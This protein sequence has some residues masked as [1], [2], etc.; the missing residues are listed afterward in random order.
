MF[1]DDECR[2][3]KIAMQRASVESAAMKKFATAAILAAALATATTATGCYGSYGA[4]HAV[5][6]WN[7][8]VTGGKV[9]NSVVHFLLWVVPVYPL[10]ATVDF[11]IL[12]NVEFITGSN[13]L[14]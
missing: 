13:P 8:T 12:N 5:H 1:S 7:G 11:L 10:A 14:K 2:R 9:G 4:F 3:Q 6:K